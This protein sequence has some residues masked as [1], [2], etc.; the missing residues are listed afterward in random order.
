MSYLG[1][2][3]IKSALLSLSAM[4]VLSTPI[5]AQD[6]APLNTDS[7]AAHLNAA[8]PVA[9]PSQDFCISIMASFP[10]DDMVARY[11][12]FKLTEQLALGATPEFKAAVTQYGDGD[13]A[14]DMP[15]IDVIE[16]IAN[17]VI[18]QAAPELTTAYMGH[19]INFAGRCESYIGGQITSL[20]AYKSALSQDD[21]VVSEDALYLR[22]ILSDSLMRLGANEDPN[23]SA[24]INGYALS[25]VAMR[26]NIEFQVYTNEIDEIEALYMTDLDGRLARSND[27]INSEINRETLSDAITLSDDMNEQARKRENQNTLATLARILGYY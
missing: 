17:P 1:N 10:N 3:L 11:Q 20:L 23:H 22:Q 14:P 2:Y 19:L 24:A 21:A 12:F 13:V 7:N 4:A 26:D 16:A 15:V 9:A 25:L 18:R 8:R 5:L 6:S 27:I